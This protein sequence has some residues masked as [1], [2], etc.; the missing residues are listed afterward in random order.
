MKIKFDEAKNTG[1][2]ESAVSHDFLIGEYEVMLEELED[3]QS[4]QK[5]R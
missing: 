4:E 1:D 5:N 3:Y 2:L